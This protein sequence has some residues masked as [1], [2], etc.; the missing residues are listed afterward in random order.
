MKTSAL[1]FLYRDKKVNTQNKKRATD[2]DPNLE[3]LE[4][5]QWEVV[6]EIRSRDI[7]VSPR[8]P[9]AVDDAQRAA[10]AE[11]QVE[12]VNELTKKLRQIKDAIEAL[13]QGRYGTCQICEREIAA[14]RLAAI[15]MAKLCISCQERVDAGINEVPEEDSDLELV[16]AD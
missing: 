14:I 6:E 12:L 13:H 4:A 16:E 2:D 15:P 10:Q 11:L 9:D 1:F 7:E 8:L 5:L 3:R